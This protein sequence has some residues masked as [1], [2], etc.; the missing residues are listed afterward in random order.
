MEAVIEEGVSPS[1]GLSSHRLLASA[2]RAG[3][4]ERR[5]ACGIA[6]LIIDADRRGKRLVCAGKLV[7]QFRSAVNAKTSAKFPS[8]DRER[9]TS[10][11]EISANRPGP[12]HQTF[13]VLADRIQVAQV[14]DSRTV[15]GETF[16]SGELE[17]HID[18]DRRCHT[19]LLR[20]AG[21]ETARERRSVSEPTKH[22]L[23]PAR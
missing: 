21:K 6:I 1:R 13:H 8:L 5:P 7:D 22:P 19:D 10:D 16:N 4:R 17:I 12:V 23:R 11:A 15:E 20:I 9:T 2:G 3:E 18:T 14:D